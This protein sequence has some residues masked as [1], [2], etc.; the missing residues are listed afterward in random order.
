LGEQIIDVKGIDV[1]YGHIQALWDMSLS[2]LE[3]EL[4]ALLGAN[5][6]GKTT[7]LKTLSGLL[8][9][10]R[11][12]I[13][14]R[15]RPI[16]GMPPEQ[17]V[18]LGL[19]QVPERRRIFPL[20]TVEENLLMGGFHQSARKGRRGAIAEV[21][22]LFPILRERQRQLA[23]T[24]SGGEQQMLAIGRA[25]VAKPRLLMLDEPSL[26]LAPTLAREIFAAVRRI[27]SSGTTVLLVEQNI[28]EALKLAER[29]YVL[30]N[31]RV[32]MHDSSSN[33]LASE[34]VRRAYLGL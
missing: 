28:H 26:G 2:I 18:G 15:G 22:E 17:I 10:G 21:F 3:G 11:G 31:G 1:G 12:E 8:R 25:L 4:V 14:F 19:I 34:H 32:I 29:G 30:E 23:G 13:F 16:H 6:A 20:M 24:L 7:T 27:N 5:G 9:P 33:L